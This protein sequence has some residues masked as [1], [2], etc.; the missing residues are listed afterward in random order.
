MSTPNKLRAVIAL[1]FSLLL[2]AAAGKAQSASEPA[3]RPKI[4]AIT[5]F[6]RLD[7][8]RYK[9]QIQDALTFLRQAKAAYEKS[10][11]EV[12]TIRITTQPFP[13]YTRDLS[14]EQAIAFFRDYDAL[15]VK[16]GLT[17]PSAPP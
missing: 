14:E 13:E 17:H 16:E 3:P 12:Q 1:L 4:R 9:D 8:T 7:R 15:A 10:G 5:A 2:V 6:V 11:Y